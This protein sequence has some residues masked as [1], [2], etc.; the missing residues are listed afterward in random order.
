M[1][2]LKKPPN[3]SFLRNKKSNI[4]SV[5]R[6]DLTPWASMDLFPHKHVSLDQHGCSPVQSS[7]GCQH[8]GNTMGPTVSVVVLTSEK[9]CPGSPTVTGGQRK[10]E[11]DLRS[12]LIFQNY[13]F[14]GK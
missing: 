8:P 7:P 9:M 13:G 11:Q 10:S 5:S 6:R 2:G 4:V 14:C 1:F 12:K 3:V